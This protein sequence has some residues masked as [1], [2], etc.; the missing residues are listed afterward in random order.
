MVAMS[1][2]ALDSDFLRKAELGFGLLE[3]CLGK[4]SPLISNL[5]DSDDLRSAQSIFD[6]I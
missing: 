4:D 5:I 1:L 3:S 2:M 6:G